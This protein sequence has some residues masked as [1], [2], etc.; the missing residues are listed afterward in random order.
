MYSPAVPCCS[1]CSAPRPPGTSSH[2]LWDL[3]CSHSRQQK[4]SPSE[5]LAPGH[6]PHAEGEGHHQPWF[7][8]KSKNN[9]D[10]SKGM[11]HASGT[12]FVLFCFVVFIYLF[13]QGSSTEMQ[14]MCYASARNIKPVHCVCH[15]KST[16]TAWGL[17]A[18]WAP[19]TTNCCAGEGCLLWKFLCGEA[20]CVGRA[21][22]AEGNGRECFQKYPRV[23]EISSTA[24]MQ[25]SVL[26][27]PN[28]WCRT[29]LN[30]SC[31][32]PV[33]IALQTDLGISI[34]QSYIVRV[35]LGKMQAGTSRELQR[36]LSNPGVQHREKTEPCTRPCLKIPGLGAV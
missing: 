33:F 8:E 27:L 14:G 23:F 25:C 36:Y 4:E 13:S 7:S 16:G 5:V 29:A 1:Q 6:C 12:S 35:H 26:R 10:E 19:G 32:H 34:L 30:G 3:I 17:A 18:H 31:A 11:R 20:L 24:E 21:E 22:R 15:T 9:R 28:D 2:Q